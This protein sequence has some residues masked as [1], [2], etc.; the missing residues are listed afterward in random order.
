MADVS[1]IT[2]P[3]STKLGVDGYAIERDLSEDM[4]VGSSRVRHASCG[5][6]SSM[7]VGSNKVIPGAGPVSRRGGA[8]P[9]RS[10]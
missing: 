5:A 7:P 6:L 8:I 3:S 10:E 2:A 1:R 4:D 9:V